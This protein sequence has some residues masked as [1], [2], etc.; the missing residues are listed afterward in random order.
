MQADGIHPNAKGV[1]TL[2]ET[3]GPEVQALLAQIK[4]P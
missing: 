1:V 2:L 4:T 3:L